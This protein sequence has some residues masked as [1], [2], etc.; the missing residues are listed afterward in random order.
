MSGWKGSNR[1]ADLPPYWDALRAATLRRARHKCEHTR[2]DTGQPC[3]SPATDA[4]HIV[5]HAEGGTDTLDN[6]QALC[7]YHHLRKSGRE[8]ARGLAR[9]RANK[10]PPPHPGI[11]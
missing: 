5:P 10:T 9:A 3:G 4:D 11:L 7:H 1:K 8:G 2:E 6:M